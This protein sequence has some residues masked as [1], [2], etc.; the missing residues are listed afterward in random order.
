M[1]FLR[2]GSGRVCSPV[3]PN[4][5]ELSEKMK[6]PKFIALVTVSIMASVMLIIDGIFSRLATDNTPALGASE[7]VPDFDFWPLWLPLLLVQIVVVALT[8][9]GLA[10]SFQRNVIYLGVFIF[11]AA[12]IYSLAGHEMLKAHLH[13]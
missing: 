5:L 8:Y 12:S 6:T 1:V 10:G 13:L 2:L 9:R 3:S 7:Q 4:D 11:I